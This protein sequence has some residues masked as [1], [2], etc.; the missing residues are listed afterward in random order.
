MI[1]LETEGLRDFTDCRDL[2]AVICVHMT[3]VQFNTFP[4]TSPVARFLVTVTTD[5]PQSSLSAFGSAVHCVTG[6]EES[7]ILRLC[8]PRALFQV[9]GSIGPVPLLQA[10]SLRQLDPLA[11]FLQSRFLDA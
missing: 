6:I 10:L 8:R 4:R 3:T 5:Q 9:S 7:H 11:G 2:K 1:S